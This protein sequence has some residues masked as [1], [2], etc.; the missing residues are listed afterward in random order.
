MNRDKY[1]LSPQGTY[2]YITNELISANSTIIVMVHGIGSC[3]LLFEDL[4]VIF[5]KAKYNVLTYDLI[6]RGRSTYPADGIF[7]GNAHVSQLRALL[8]NFHAEEKNLHLHLICHSM[9]GVIGTLYACSYP[10]EIE[11]LTLLAPAGLMR[12]GPVKF[13]RGS[14]ACLQ[15]YL[16]NRALKPNQ[17]KAW[18]QDFIA[19]TPE[20]K[21]IQKRCVEILRQV[22]TDNPQAFD[23][24]F[25]VFYNFPCM[26][27]IPM[28][29]NYQ[30]FLSKSY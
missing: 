2:Y 7:D 6:G 14:P 16:K 22:S 3:S 4:I 8:Q 9:G 24:F 5:E 11:S 28:Q 19:S 26:A 17:E 25:K 18:K 1:K 27:L 23:A 10:H 15:S 29:F 20:G 30:S 12:P 21:Q 13:L